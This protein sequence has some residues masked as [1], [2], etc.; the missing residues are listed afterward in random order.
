MV[1][2]RNLTGSRRQTAGCNQTA[3]GA[4]RLAGAA[5]DRSPLPCLSAPSPRAHLRRNGSRGKRR[6]RQGLEEKGV[7]ICDAYE[8]VLAMTIKIFQIHPR[9]NNLA[10]FHHMRRAETEV[11]P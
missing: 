4:W 9:I 5:W 6:T 8:H 3:D 2:Q 11:N 1:G 10:L 7:F